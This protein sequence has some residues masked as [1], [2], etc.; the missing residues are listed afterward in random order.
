MK[1]GHEMNGYIK[2]SVA[3]LLRVALQDMKGSVHTVIL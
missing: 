2:M 3:W 1:L